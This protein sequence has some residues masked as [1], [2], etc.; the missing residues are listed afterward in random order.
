MML[1]ILNRHG[2]FKDIWPIISQNP[3]INVVI[4]IALNLEFFI[5]ATRFFWV[6]QQQRGVK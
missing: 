3:I 5:L 1:S 2:I 4:W 6:G